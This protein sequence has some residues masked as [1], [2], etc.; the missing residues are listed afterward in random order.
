MLPTSIA[1]S[2]VI[3]LPGDVSPALDRA[4]VDLAEGEVAAGHDAAQVVVGA[5]GAGDVAA[6][7]EPAAPASSR[8]ST[9]APAPTGP[10]K[11]GGPSARLDLLAR[12]WRGA[13]PSAFAELDLVDAVVAAHEHEH[14]PLAA[15]AVGDHHG[16]GLQQRARREAELGGDVGDRRHARAWRPAPAPRRRPAASTGC[17]SAL[18]TS[19]FAA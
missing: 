12:A 7:A 17:A 15:L 19:T 8:I 3:G 1:G 6:R 10:M 18:A 11:P 14:Q 13:A 4:H 2:I 9:S 16:V 5:V